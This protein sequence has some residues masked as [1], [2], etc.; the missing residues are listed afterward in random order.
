M[1]IGRIP[2]PEQ[3][4]GDRVAGLPVRWRGRLLDKWLDTMAAYPQRVA[5][6]ELREA[7]EH[8]EKIRLPLSASDEQ[9]R[10]EAKTLAAQCWQVGRL[11][12]RDAEKVRQGMEQFCRS[13][14]VEPPDEDVAY[15]G[16]VGRMS[17]GTWWTRQL[18]KLHAKTVE[19]AAISLGY[20]NRARDCYVSNESLERR[21]QQNRRNNRMMENTLL[22]NEL[23]DEFTLAELAAKGVANKSIRRGELMTRIAGFERIATDCGHEGVFLTVTC[24]SRMHKWISV[25]QRSAVAENKKF[26]GTTPKEAQKYLSAVWAR[27]RAALARAKLG[28]YGFRVA[29]PHHDAC[30]HWHLLLFHFAGAGKQIVEIF[31]RYALADSPDERGA[32]AHRVKA[33]V[34]DA[35]KGTAA[36]YIAKYI[37]KNIDG[38]HVGEDL[39]GNPAMETSGRVE[40]WA[41]TWGIRQF[42]QIGGAPVGVWRELRRV[43]E[44]PADA[45]ESLKIAHEA[46]NRREVGEE[47]KPAAW[48]AYIRAQ[49]GA[50]VG[51]GA[52]IS[53]AVEESDEVG[54]YGEIKAPATI[55][56]S[57][58]DYVVRSARHVWEVV[59]GGF[60]VLGGVISAPWTGVNNC[61]RWEGE[62]G[63][64]QKI[65]SAIVWEKHIPEGGGGGINNFAFG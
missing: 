20:V 45:P 39:F 46:V 26:D 13:H 21:R 64:N 11:Q 5:N 24:P 44:L 7:V 34:M 52:E 28:V 17:C 8:L 59:K 61:T 36:A 22:R 65:D 33:V 35:S 12:I 62:N 6:I 57:V 53:L 16:A 2:S 29:E 60:K 43:K 27:I 25:G 30:P 31:K 48:D 42:Q 40:A 15:Q 56:V 19:G 37:A 9:I 14:N 55:G 1:S 3:W 63:R 23:G 58:A 38:L 41:A 4:A 50:F 47:V 51:R 32:A 49:G 18:R 54:R 10:T